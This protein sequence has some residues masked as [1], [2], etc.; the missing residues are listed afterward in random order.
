MGTIVCQDCQKV[1]EHYENEK[2]STLYGTCPT[3]TDTEE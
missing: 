3:C 1:I 2:V